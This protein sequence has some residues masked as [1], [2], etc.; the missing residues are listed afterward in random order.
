[1]NGAVFY[2]GQTWEAYVASMRK[3]R[4]LVA[5]QVERCRLP[6]AEAERWAAAKHVA[7]VLVFTEDNCQDSVS[8]LPPL[9]AIA[10]AAAFDLR[11]MRRNERLDLQRS[12]TGLEYPPV[13]LFLFYDA[14][15]RLLGRFVEMPRAFRA[16]KE[17]P[18]ESFWLRDQETYDEVWWETEFAELAAIAEAAP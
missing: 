15:W 13:P 8:A 18:E 14:D 10:R 6:P 11:V 12:L 3:Y 1:M 4:R 5:R 2:S 16:L 9:L 7:H 17:D